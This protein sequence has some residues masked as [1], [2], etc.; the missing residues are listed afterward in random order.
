MRSETGFNLEWATEL[1]IVSLDF[2]RRERYA[3]AIYSVGSEVGAMKEG[4]V[5]FPPRMSSWCPGIMVTG[6]ASWA[7]VVKP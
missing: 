6:S 5:P 3:S 7:K 4:R 2:K 1:H